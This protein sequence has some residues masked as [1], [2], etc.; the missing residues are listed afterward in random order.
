MSYRSLDAAK[1]IE[2]CERL[3]LRVAERFPKSGLAEV[4]REVLQVARE[5]KA[6]AESIQRPNYALRILIGLLVL[7]LLSLPA[8]VWIPIRWDTQA[9]EWTNV[10]QTLEA[11]VTNTVF[12][13][14]AIVFLSTL[15][16]RM[17]RRRAL[18]ALHELRSLAHIVDM[19]QLTKS[20]EKILR[21]G[22]PTRHSPQRTMTSFQLCRYFDYC[23]ELLSMLNKISAIYVQD[24]PD[25][26][27]LE[28]VE[29]VEDLTTNLG[30]QIWQKMMALD[31]MDPQR[32]TSPAEERTSTE[33]SASE[34]PSHDRDSGKS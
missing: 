10:I 4:A 24:F 13:G 8:L 33:E 31:L 30:R 1:I 17:H 9:L 28:A 25:P 14:A 5:A 20:P 3:Q 15:E 29:Q 27:T 12:L 34:N 16:V 23:M 7:G 32:E 26:P 21:G 6:R 19:H 18:R 2:T 11:L 22:A